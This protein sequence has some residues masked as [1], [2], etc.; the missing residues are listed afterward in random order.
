MVKSKLTQI[1]Q[2]DFPIFVKWLSPLL[3]LGGSEVK[4]H[5]QFI[6][7]EIHGSKLKSPRWDTIFCDITSGAILFA[8]VP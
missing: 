2:I 6:F 3:F 1:S 4:F 8:F 5:F 7:D